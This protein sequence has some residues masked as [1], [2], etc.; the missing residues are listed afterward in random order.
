MENKAYSKVGDDINQFKLNG[1]VRFSF[2]S[3]TTNKAK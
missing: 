2:K 3:L 1:L